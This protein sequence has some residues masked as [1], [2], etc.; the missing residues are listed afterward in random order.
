VEQAWIEQ[1]VA[2]V[3]AQLQTAAPRP[4]S[5]P[6]LAMSASAGSAQSAPSPGT[7]RPAVDIAASASPAVLELTQPVITAETLASQVRPGVSL[8]IS[9]RSVLTPSAR[10]WLNSKKISWSRLPRS[11]ASMTERRS[12]GRWQLLVQSAPPQVRTLLENLKRHPEGWS[13]EL[14]GTASETV[15][16]VTRALCTAESDGVVVISES[17]ERIAC[18]AN[19]NTQVR[20]AVISDRRHLERVH[21]QLGVNLVCLDPLGRTF[22]E[23]RNLLRDCRSRTPAAPAGLTDA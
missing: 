18:L 20:A 21:E 14:V 2:N 4:V 22:I 1:I 19:R 6:S 23:L 7:S 16:L 8:K 3:L 9:R 5:T 13:V 11:A 10:D 15:S 17:A 12:A